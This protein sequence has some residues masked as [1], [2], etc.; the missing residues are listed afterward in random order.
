VPK[1]LRTFAIEL[2]FICRI[3]EELLLTKTTS[4][5]ESTTKLPE[6]D[7]ALK[8]RALPTLSS[9]YDVN[10]RTAE[11]WAGGCDFF[12]SHA[13]SAIVSRMR[14]VV[15]CCSVNLEKVSSRSSDLAASCGL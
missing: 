10:P 6:F 2:A 13:N 1:L 9:K 7:D 11:A 4:L 8:T 15:P 14:G 12:D 3:G 5:A